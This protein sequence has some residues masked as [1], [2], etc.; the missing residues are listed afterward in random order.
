MRF[1]K[2]FTIGIAAAI[3]S[4]IVFLLISSASSYHELGWGGFV[5]VEIVVGPW[6]LLL[7]LAAFALGFFWTLKRTS[8]KL[9]S[10]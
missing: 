4:A 10:N 7:M 9:I 5:A 1:L 3:V 6:L 8:R 2:S